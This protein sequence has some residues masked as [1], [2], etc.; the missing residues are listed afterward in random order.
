MTIWR[1]LIACWILKAI[2]T[3]TEY[4]ILNAFQLQQL[5]HKRT[6]LL[7]YTYTDCFVVTGLSE[8]IIFALLSTLRNRPAYFV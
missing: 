5:L 4:V 1:M 6:S 2:S 8:I 3:H 7:R